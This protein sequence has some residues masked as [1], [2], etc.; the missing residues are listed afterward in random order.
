MHPENV[1]PDLPFIPNTKLVFNY[2][3]SSG[4]HPLHRCD[5]TV[6]KERKTVKQ[7]AREMK[8]IFT[9]KFLKIFLTYLTD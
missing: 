9:S 7:N 2:I 3:T 6:K 4:T 8:S 5:H 1:S